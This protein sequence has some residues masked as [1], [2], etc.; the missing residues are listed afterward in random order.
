MTKITICEN[1]HKIKHT[2]M[3]PRKSDK[4][5]PSILFRQ[6][7]LEYCIRCRAKIVKVEDL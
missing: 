2:K 4:E 7:Y 1:G 6:G 5:A 3:N